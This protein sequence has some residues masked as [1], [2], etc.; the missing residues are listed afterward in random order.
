MKNYRNYPQNN[1][2]HQHVIQFNKNKQINKHRDNN[3]II[4]INLD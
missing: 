4:S 2:K 3:K 1:S